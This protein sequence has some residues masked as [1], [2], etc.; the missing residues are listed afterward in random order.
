[1][2]TRAAQ[3]E[4]ATRALIRTGLSSGSTHGIVPCSLL[5]SAYCFFSHPHL[6]RPSTTRR[7]RA[8]PISR[9]PPGNSLLPISQIHDCTLEW[10]NFIYSSSLYFCKW[11]TFPHLCSFW[12]PSTLTLHTAFPQTFE[13]IIFRRSTSFKLV[14]RRRPETTFIAQQKH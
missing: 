9:S 10:R 11:L 13:A 2:G 3:R 6:L 7:T 1:M 8:G 4:A 5:L 14:G 12:Y